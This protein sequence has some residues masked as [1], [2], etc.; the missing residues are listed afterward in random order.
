MIYTEV[1]VLHTTILNLCF[2]LTTNGAL[3]LLCF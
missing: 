1:S 2:M 3:V